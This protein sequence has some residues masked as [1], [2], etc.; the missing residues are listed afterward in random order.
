MGTDKKHRT[1]LCSVLFTDIVSYTKFDV[2]EQ[3]DIRRHFYDL[4]EEELKNYN[5]DD[6]ITLD[7]G[8]GMAICYLGDPEDVL[9]MALSLRDAFIR[10][11]S[12]QNNIN[13]EVRLGINL[14]PVKIAELQGEKRVIGDAINVAN[15][16]MGF[17][18]PNELYISRS[19][20]E[21]VSHLS[22]E[23]FNMFDFVGTRE[24]KHVRKHDVYT[25]G[26]ATPTHEPTEAPPTISSPAPIT[27]VTMTPNIQPAVQKQPQVEHS[28]ESLKQVEQ[29]LSEYIGPLAKVLVKKRAAKAKN[30]TELS[31]LLAKEIET[32]SERSHFLAACQ[33]LT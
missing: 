8:D 27:P 18:G 4:V 26:A 30:I 7:A 9:L 2:E 24:D 33:K 15:R 32:P 10:I 25:V 17:A 3:M 1:W 23:Y 22:K 6:Y 14:G 31:E 13:Y 19:Y 20:Y 21:V 11:K 16:I 12:E 28:K 29:Y 5:R